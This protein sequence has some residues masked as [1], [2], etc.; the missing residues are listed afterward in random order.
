LFV[1]LGW[2]PKISLRDGLTSLHGWLAGRFGNP[3]KREAFA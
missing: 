3:S 2:Q 1:A